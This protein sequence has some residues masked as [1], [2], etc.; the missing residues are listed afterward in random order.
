LLFFLKEWTF[1]ESL[2]EFPLAILLLFRELLNVKLADII[3]PEGCVVSIYLHTLNM[4]IILYIP[5]P[6]LLYVQWDAIKWHAPRNRQS[7]QWV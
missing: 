7:W 2:A 3:Q 6:P 1:S 4:H 5:P